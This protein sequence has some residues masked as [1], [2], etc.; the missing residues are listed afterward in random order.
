MTCSSDTDCPINKTCGG[1]GACYVAE[2]ILDLKLDGSDGSTSFTDDSS[3]QRTVSRGGNAHVSNSNPAFC[4]HNS[5]SLY[6]GDYLTIESSAFDELESTDYTIQFWINTAQQ[7]E[8]DRLL[9]FESGSESRGLIKNYGDLHW[10]YFGT[11]SPLSTGMFSNND[12]HFI[13]VTKA[14]SDHRLFVDGEL[15]STTSSQLIPSGASRLTIGASLNTYILSQ[16]NANFANL[17]IIKGVSIYNS[18][19]SA[20]TCTDVRTPSCGNSVVEGTEQCDGGAN[21][22][23]CSCDAGYSPDGNGACVAGYSGIE[24]NTCYSMGSPTADSYNYSGNQT[25]WCSSTS[26][27]Y[28]SGNAQNGLDQDGTGTNTSDNN[29]YYYAGSKANGNYNSYYYIDGF[30]TQLDSMGSGAS[31]H[32]GTM[33]CYYYGSLWETNSSLNSGNGTGYCLI[34]QYYYIGGTQTTLDSNGSGSY[35]NYYYLSGHQTTLNSSGSGVWD[36]GYGLKCYENSSA[37]NQLNN[38]TGYCSQTD[39]YYL[40]GTETTLDSSGNGWW[41]GD[42]YSSGTIDSLSGSEFDPTTSP[43][44]SCG[45]SCIFSSSSITFTAVSGGDFYADSSQWTFVNGAT[46]SWNFIYTSSN[47]G[48]VTGNAT[49]NNYGSGDYGN[50][51]TVNGDATF[52]YSSI[53]NGTV[54]G[55]PTYNGYSGWSNSVSKYFIHGQQTTLDSNGD[56]TW[57]NQTYENGTITENTT[58][59]STTNT[60]IPD[61]SGAGGAGGGDSGA[62]GAGGGGDTNFDNVTALFHYDSTLTNS[63]TPTPSSRKWT[64]SFIGYNEGLVQFSNTSKWGSQSLY[65]TNDW[66][67]PEN[68]WD[69][70]TGAL[71]VTNP[72][73]SLP[74]NFTFET[75]FKPSTTWGASTWATLFAYGKSSLDQIDGVHLWYS[76]NKLIFDFNNNDAYPYLTGKA[77]GTVGTIAANTWHHV[78]GVK[79]GEN[80]YIYLDGNRVAQGTLNQFSFDTWQDEPYSGPVFFSGA[81]Y[82]GSTVGLSIGS[83]IDEWGHY[84][85]TWQGYMDDTRFTENAARYTGSTYTVPTAAFPNN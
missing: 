45:N 40:S 60:T 23:S 47:Q 81:G 76:G 11:W 48:T 72:P 69:P 3:Y 46:I 25:G 49:F 4:G 67:W 15:K 70:I 71:Q 42:H 65:F 83:L 82:S 80:L 38:G 19:F 7:G 20:P 41:S 39:K 79:Y 53:D 61:G 9:V 36:D 28:I 10:N 66:Q 34:T 77:Q 78:A 18:S 62:G 17:K 29:L 21:C 27:Y 44:S 12:W 43:V 14:G 2:T 75:W 55:T 58:S 30:Q 32:T 64:G 31:D 6:N 35:N 73:S 50:F 84:S 63:A 85:F 56:G 24:N 22:T 1:D 74:A 26:T 13:A 33:K 16:V 37:N 59:S 51:G 54:T 68:A 52:N 8:G 5:V 57:N